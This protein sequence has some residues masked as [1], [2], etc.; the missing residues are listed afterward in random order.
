MNGEAVSLRPEATAAALKDPRAVAVAGFI[1]GVFA[2]VFGVLI[3][4]RITISLTLTAKERSSIEAALSEQRSR[5]LSPE[6][7][8]A[9][10]KV[11]EAQRQ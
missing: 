3:Y 1:L 7:R 6:E 5:S 9:I 2:G 11:L 4:E 8:A 10:E